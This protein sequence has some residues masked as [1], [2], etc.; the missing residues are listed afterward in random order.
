MNSPYFNALL[1]INLHRNYLQNF[2]VII[3]LYIK[4]KMIL[5]SDAITIFHV[6]RLK[7]L[8][9]SFETAC[10]HPL[11]DNDQYV[12]SE[13]K[14][15]RGDPLTYTTVEFKILLNDNSELSF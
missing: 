10:E 11:H 1:P 6:T 7:L 3:L 5:L 14:A 2:Q 15:Y 4:S 9:S 8:V 13:I 12:T